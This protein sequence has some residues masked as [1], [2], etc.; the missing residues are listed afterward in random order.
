MVVART[1]I[2]ILPERE[3]LLRIFLS[4]V[5]A[6]TRNMQLEAKIREQENLALVGSVAGRIISDLKQPISTIKMA[7]QI[8][9]L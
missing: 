5:D 2:Q 8:Q 4:H 3:D 7:S 1:N 6:F 9:S